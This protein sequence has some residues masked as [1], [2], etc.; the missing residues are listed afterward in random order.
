MCVAS[1]SFYTHT[2]THTHLPCFIG[3]HISFICSYMPPDTYITLI[4]RLGLKTR[5]AGEKVAITKL[6]R[7]RR[8]SHSWSHDKSVPK[9]RAP[10]WWSQLAMRSHQHQKPCHPLPT[11]SLY[12]LSNSAAFPR[13]SQ[14]PTFPNLSLDFVHLH[15]IVVV[16]GE[17]NLRSQLCSD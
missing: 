3:L 12:E 9:W 2:H 6:I 5:L 1:T 10:R 16:V 11:K 7:K 17:A 8:P 13:N 14:L 15:F 4:F